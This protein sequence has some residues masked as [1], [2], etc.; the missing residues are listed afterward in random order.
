MRTRSATNIQP[1][2]NK[3]KNNPTKVQKVNLIKLSADVHKRDYKICRQVGDQNI[4]PAQIFEPQEAFEWALKQL[5]LAERVVFCYEAGFSGFSLAR[6][7]EQHG[8]E[9]VVM[10]PQQLDERCKRVNTDRR[11]AR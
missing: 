9:A 8:I 2:T 4:Q 7:L 5:D 6:R 3:H 1:M 10:C 11:D